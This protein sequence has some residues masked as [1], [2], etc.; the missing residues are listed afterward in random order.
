MDVKVDPSSAPDAFGNNGFFSLVVRNTGNYDYNQQFGDNIKAADGWRHI[1][2][3]PLTGGFNDIRGVTWQ[4]YGG[5]SQ[6]ISGPVTLWID[7]VA[8]TPEPASIA[9]LWG[10]GH[11]PSEP[12]PA[13]SPARQYP[14]SHL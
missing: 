3:S 5:P 6:N 13:L 4:L 14:Y 1:S 9:L 10:R 11:W 12:A 7:N 8:F 2:V